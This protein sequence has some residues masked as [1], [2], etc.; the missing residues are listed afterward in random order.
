MHI[1]VFEF[2]LELT[3]LALLFVHNHK[4]RV[5]ILRWQIRDLRCLTGIL[6]STEIFFEI[7]VGR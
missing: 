6:Q 3:Y 7:F 5:D 4:F 1:C 2:L